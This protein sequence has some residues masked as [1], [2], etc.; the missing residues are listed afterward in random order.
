[1]IKSRSKENFMYWQNLANNQ[2]AEFAKDNVDNLIRL[3]KY[4]KKT[5]DGT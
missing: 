1:M 5:I 4:R 2:T 3:V